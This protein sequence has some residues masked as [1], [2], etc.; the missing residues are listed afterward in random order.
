MPPPRTASPRSRPR[1]RSAVTP[2]RRSPATG[3]QPRSPRATVATTAPVPRP[4]TSRVRDPRELAHARARAQAPR[5]AR[6][7]AAW[8]RRRATLAAWS[9]RA[10][11]VSAVLAVLLVAAVALAGVPS[12]TPGPTSTPL[13]LTARAIQLRDALQTT[14]S[15]LQRATDVVAVA[16]TTLRTAEIAREEAGAALTLARTTV[17]AAAADLY[18]QPT[19]SR[20]TAAGLPVSA[21][22]T[23]ATD[24]LVLSTAA[25]RARAVLTAGA[26]AAALHPGQVAQRTPGQDDARFDRL[27]GQPGSDQGLRPGDRTAGCDDDVGPGELEAALGSRSQHPLRRA[28]GGGRQQRLVGVQQQDRSLDAALHDDV[29]GAVLGGRSD[30]EDIAGAGERIRHPADDDAPAVHGDLPCQGGLGRI[31]PAQDGDAAASRLGVGHRPKA[32]PAV[33]R[34][35]QAGR[36]EIELGAGDVHGELAELGARGTFGL[37]DD[38]SGSPAVLDDG[39]VQA[40]SSLGAESKGRGEQIRRVTGDPAQPGQQA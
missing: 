35:V 2:A 34:R 14:S 27:A 30:R 25:D 1:P 36:T 33:Q 31:G 17:G 19:A 6:R 15:D 40:R 10:G 20:L 13:D 28:A 23:S 21:D 38:Q 3:A 7:A 18:R 16:D 26:S 8:R 39:Q 37:L 22:P 4:G 9:A 5:A 29:S 24:L 12:Q 11:S 32:D